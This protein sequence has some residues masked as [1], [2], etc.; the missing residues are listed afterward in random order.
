MSQSQIRV[1]AHRAADL[2]RVA[3]L[4]SRF[5][6]RGNQVTPQYVLHHLK[7]AYQVGWRDGAFPELLKQ[8]E[9][10]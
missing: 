7:Y 10:V 1:P 3:D 6:A 9:T 2:K 5:S 4:V 8:E